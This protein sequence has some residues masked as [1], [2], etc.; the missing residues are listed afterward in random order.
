MAR[1]IGF[2]DK[3]QLVDL[4][5]LNF[6]KTLNIDMDYALSQ[7]WDDTFRAIRPGLGKYKYKSVRINHQRCKVPCKNILVWYLIDFSNFA[8]IK[9]HFF[10]KGNQNAFFKIAEF[11]YGS[12]YRCWS[13][14][15]GHGVNNNIVATN[16]LMSQVLF[17]VI[18]AAWEYNCIS[19]SEKKAPKSIKL[20]NDLNDITNAANLIV[21]NLN[22]FNEDLFE[23]AYQRVVSGKTNGA[24]LRPE[25][26]EERI[27]KINNFKKYHS[28]YAYIENIS[29]LPKIMHEIEADLNALNSTTNTTG[30][31]LERSF[32]GPDLLL[33]SKASL[34][35]DC[36]ATEANSSNHDVLVSCIA[37]LIASFAEGTDPIP[38]L[39]KDDQIKIKEKSAN[40]LRRI[41][42]WRIQ[43]KSYLETPNPS[44][45]YRQKMITLLRGPGPAWREGLVD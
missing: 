40:S 8:Q 37:L 41:K 20:K 28:K 32:G 30:T 16:S 34:L 44:E 43:L 7:R 31:I 3:F 12:K 24:S 26:K 6:E 39:T 1:L 14:P 29:I 9:N 11:L 18:R 10:P 21:S 4:I 5:G 35:V 42:K 23:Q 19:S 22:T 17:S 36:Y 45:E 2:Q 27:D 25:S 13:A 38:M 15:L 33:Y